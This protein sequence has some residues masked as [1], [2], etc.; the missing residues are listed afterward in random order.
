M[1]EKFVFAG[2]ILGK[3]STLKLVIM[4]GAKTRKAVSWPNYNISN[5]YTEKFLEYEDG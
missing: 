5:Q 1:I 2:Y 3:H 4:T